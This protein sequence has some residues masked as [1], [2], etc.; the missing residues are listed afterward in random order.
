MKQ[1]KFDLEGI[2]RETFFPFILRDARDNKEFPDIRLEFS[3]TDWLRS[4][5]KDKPYLHTQIYNC[6]DIQGLV[7]ATRVLN[8]LEPVTEGMH[9][10]SESSTCYIH[11]IDYEEC[12]QT[13]DLCSRMIQSEEL[14]HKAIT[15]SEANEYWDWD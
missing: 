1:P 11:F 3:D 13:A 7:I 12:C 15:L 4:R 2:D 6:Y 5:Y 9:L 10:N 8:N 14:L